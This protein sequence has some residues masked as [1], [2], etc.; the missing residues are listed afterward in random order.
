VK[1]NRTGSDGNGRTFY[2]PATYQF[3]GRPGR[4]E[5]TLARLFRQRGAMDGHP[6][7]DATEYAFY[8][9]ASTR[10]AHVRRGKRPDAR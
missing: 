7:P 3:S 8:V 10:S 9:P 2:A 1:T 6:R 5:R 4:V